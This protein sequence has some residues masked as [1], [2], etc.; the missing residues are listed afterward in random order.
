MNELTPKIN[1]D[2]SV[3]TI[4]DTLDSLSGDIKIVLPITIKPKH[5]PLKKQ[6]PNALF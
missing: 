4:I 3:N 1:L 6:S 5:K 2:S